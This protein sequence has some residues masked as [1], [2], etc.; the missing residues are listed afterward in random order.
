[1]FAYTQLV[2][3]TLKKVFFVSNYQV[4]KRSVFVTALK[5]FLD[6]RAIAFYLYI[7]VCF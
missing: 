5:K 7:G 3:I 4:G 2:L 6:I 1:M